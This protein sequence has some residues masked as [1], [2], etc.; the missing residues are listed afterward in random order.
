MKRPDIRVVGAILLIVAGVLFLLQNLGILGGAIALL[1]ALLF[2][3]GGALFLYVFLVN[4]AN[5]W[6]IIPGFALLSL[7]ATVAV[8]EL[9]PWV[10]GSWTGTIFL[11]GI[12]LGFWVVYFFNREHWWAAIPGG[13]LITIGLVTGLSSVLEGFEVGGIF[14]IG[15]GLTFALLSRLR[16]PEGRMQ[17]ALVPAGVMLVMGLVITAAATELL[18]DWWPVGLI[19]AGLYIIISAFAFRRSE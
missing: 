6:A 17:W 5:W 3:T 18:R 8:S 7:A 15:L 11:A 12:G 10:G 4:R 9:L 16:T 13:V 1:W 19:L 2:G 14:F